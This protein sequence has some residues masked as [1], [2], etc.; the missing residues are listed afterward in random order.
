MEKRFT[1][2]Y[3]TDITLVFYK[4]EQGGYFYTRVYEPVEE[5]H[6][7]TATEPGGD[8]TARF[9]ATDWNTN[10]GTGL[11]SAYLIDLEVGRVEDVLYQ[12]GDKAWS[13]SGRIW[14]PSVD[15]Y[16]LGYSLAE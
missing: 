8:P 1:V 4:D 11:H 16:I 2:T 9:V 6:T 10:T 13:K 15:G 3:V 12:D 7:F 5:G 14:E